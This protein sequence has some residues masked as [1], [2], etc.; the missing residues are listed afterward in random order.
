M[1]DC[2]A[3]F[4]SVSGANQNIQEGEMNIQ[5]DPRNIK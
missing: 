3:H 2:A 1:E 5:E 4:G